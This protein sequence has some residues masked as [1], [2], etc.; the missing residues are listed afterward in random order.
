MINVNYQADSWIGNRFINHF[1]LGVKEKI[2]THEKNTLEKAG[3]V[4]LW[5]I[6]KFPRKVWCAAK[7]PKIVTIALTGFSLI[8]VSFAFYPAQTTTV[9]KK[10]ICQIIP[11]ISFSTAKFAIYLTL[12]GTIIATSMRAQ[13]RFWNEELMKQFYSQNNQAIH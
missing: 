12:V 6:E 3:D 2:G 9:L 13:G 5:F 7:N 4:G 11:N 8:T 1:I 10:T